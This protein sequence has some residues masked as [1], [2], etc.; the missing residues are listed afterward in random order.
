MNTASYA[1][2]KA[3]GPDQWAP[4]DLK[5]WSHKAFSWLAD[6][7]NVI[8][9]QKVWPKEMLKVR[10]A[11]MAKDVQKDKDPLAYRVLLMMPAVYRLWAK[12]RLSH[13]APWINL[14]D[15]EEIF[16]G[17]GAN[18][19]EEAWYA[20]AL[21]LEELSIEGIDFTGCSHF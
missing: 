7:L 5:L 19:G 14:W 9:E 11:F 13:L 17:A 20:L 8:E 2:E 21:R 15:M 3:V 12:V 18:G 10:A 16:A 1:K 4:A 6:M